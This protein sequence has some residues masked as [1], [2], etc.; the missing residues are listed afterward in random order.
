MVKYTLADEK[1]EKSL[2]LRLKHNTNNGHVYVRAFDG[3]GREWFVVVFTPS[4]KLDL[5][6]GL[7]RDIGLQVD[8]DGCIKLERRLL[9]GTT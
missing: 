8:G 9:G 5:Y 1:P 4:G 7:P 2:V 6:G 3:K